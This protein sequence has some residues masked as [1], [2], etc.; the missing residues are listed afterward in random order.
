MQDSGEASERSSSHSV[1]FVL[2]VMECLDGI[3]PGGGLL[4]TV[5]NC[6]KNWSSQFPAWQDKTHRYKHTGWSEYFPLILP[7]LHRHLEAPRATLRCRIGEWLAWSGSISSYRRRSLKQQLH[8]PPLV[9]NQ[10]CRFHFGP[11]R[12][13]AVTS[14]GPWVWKLKADRTRTHKASCSY[15]AGVSLCR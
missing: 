14:S 8:L 9:T 11:G 6:R 1:C 3:L 2:E 15:R 12:W 4:L 13:I 5:N 7:E 10:S